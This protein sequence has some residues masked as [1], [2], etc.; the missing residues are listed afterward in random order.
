MDP[1]N[2]IQ[3]ASETAPQASETA[4][5]A[6]ETVPQAS[7]TADQITDNIQ[8]Q[9]KRLVL[10]TS[11]EIDKFDDV[12]SLCDLGA[13][14]GVADILFVLRCDP[15]FFGRER[16]ERTLTLQ[17]GIKKD[18]LKNKDLSG[19]DLREADLRRADFM[20]AELR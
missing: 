6:S 18:L 9:V 19:V 10:A 2:K 16:E 14:I 4:P 7:E 20:E 11:L 17:E 12:E 1:I 13:D 15:K 5:Q 8:R 3:Q